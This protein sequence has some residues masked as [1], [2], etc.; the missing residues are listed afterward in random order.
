MLPTS[1]PLA[2]IAFLA[3]VLSFISPCVLPLV[4]AYISYL[5]V[6]AGQQTRPSE[7]ALTNGIAAAVPVSRIALFLH[8]LMFVLG[9]S[10]VFVFFGLA[11][12]TGLQLI[13][14]STYD[15]QIWT[16]RIGGILVIFFGL[17]VLN[18]WG[19]LLAQMAA[20]VASESAV[21]RLL[22]RITAFLYGD[23][24]RQMSRDGRGGYVGSLLM[25]I[26]FAAGWTPCIGP[27]YGS[28]LTFATNVSASGAVIPLIAYSFGIGLPFLIAAIGLDTI[29]PL[30]RA[31]QKRMRLVE[32][33]S[34][35]LLIFMGF[36]LVSG[37]MSEITA[38]FTGLADYQYRLEECTVA[39]AQGEI[40]G[41][42]HG[43]CMDVGASKVKKMRACDAAINAG[44]LPF[45]SREVCLEKGVTEAQKQQQ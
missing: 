1:L 45:S 41:A 14:I 25:G 29:K 34:G 8:G 12:N 4:P 18:V 19:F 13:G 24:R 44:T 11:V 37:R 43:L 2:S 32:L 6:R 9:M 15:I 26:F 22:Q 31:I 5:G 33:V 39:L 38:K 36:L 28:I 27:I 30:F 21:G 16:A 7:L 17:H 35:L 20:R 23:T 42:D 40:T 10:F 3:G